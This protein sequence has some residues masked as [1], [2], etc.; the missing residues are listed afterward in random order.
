M[1]KMPRWRRVYDIGKQ[2]FDWTCEYIPASKN[3]F[4]AQDKGFALTEWIIL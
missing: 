3:N 1:E 4:K 2:T